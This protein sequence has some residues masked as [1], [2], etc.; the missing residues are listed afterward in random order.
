MTGS[1]KAIVLAVG[2]DTLFE[3]EKR[4]SEA[5]H[6]KCA[7]TIDTEIETPL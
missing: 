5:N 2:K 4:E 6:T 7:F 1:G 3:T